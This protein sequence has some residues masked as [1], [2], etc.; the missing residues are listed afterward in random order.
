MV[1]DTGDGCDV[2]YLGSSYHMLYL[3]QIHWPMFTIDHDKIVADSPKQFYEVW[4]ETAD[5][6]TKNY[7]ALT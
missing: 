6:R 3:I 1:R 7:I 4:R 2:E 5:N